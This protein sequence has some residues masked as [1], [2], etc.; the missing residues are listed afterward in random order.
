[1]DIQVLHMRNTAGDEVLAVFRKSHSLSKPTLKICEIF[2]SAFLDILTPHD[3]IRFDNG[4]VV[5][6]VSYSDLVQHCIT[7]E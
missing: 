7:I 2:R 6:S 3:Q 1:M 5:F 4:N